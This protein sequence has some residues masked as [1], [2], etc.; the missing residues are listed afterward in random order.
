MRGKTRRRTRM[1]QALAILMA[2]GSAG[3]VEGLA[4]SKLSAETRRVLDRMDARAKTLNSLTRSETDQGDYR[5][6]RRG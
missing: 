5:G 3:A 6:G 1:A 4:Q 2:V